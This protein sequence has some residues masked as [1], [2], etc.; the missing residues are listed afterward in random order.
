MMIIFLFIFG[1][2]IKYVSQAD[3]VKPIQLTDALRNLSIFPLEKYL[4]TVA[5]G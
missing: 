5:A 3:R 1:L 4:E 2:L